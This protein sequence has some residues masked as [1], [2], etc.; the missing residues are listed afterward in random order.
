MKIS[1][2]IIA[3]STGIIISVLNSNAQTNGQTTSAQNS[4][5]YSIGAEGG[6]V[7]NRF[8]DTHKA[9]V[10]GSLQADIPV[11]AQFYATINAGYN[12]FIGEKNIYGSGISAADLHLLPVMAGLKFFPVPLFY[13]QG[14]A[15]AAF[16]LNKNNNGFDKTAA[17]I[18]APQL[19]VQ[20]PV[21]NKSFIDAGVKYEGSTKFA[22]GVDDSKLS[23][24]GIRLAYAF[25][26]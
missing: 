14:D 23:F 13:I 5:I 11:A 19:G 18:Y 26:L 16:A 10:G 17:F 6:I 25:S 2:K 8:K 4:I 21:G 9:Y 1:I 15:G 20:I 12:D 24:F 3:I 7:T 22:S